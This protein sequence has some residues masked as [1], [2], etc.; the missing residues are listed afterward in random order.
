MYF[1]LIPSRHRNWQ[2]ADSGQTSTFSSVAAGEEGAGNEED[3][4]RAAAGTRSLKTSQGM[5]PRSVAGGG[6]VRSISG[7][8]PSGEGSW[9]RGIAECVGAA[10]PQSAL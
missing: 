1:C 2:Q 7:S 5:F 10:E 6:H 4:A 3:D 8:R 9:A